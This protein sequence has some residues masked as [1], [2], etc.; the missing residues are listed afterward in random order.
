[1]M[2]TAKTP[3]LARRSRMF[4][5]AWRD[6]HSKNISIIK[7]LSH[8]LVRVTWCKQPKHQYS[9]GGLTFFGMLDMMHTTKTPIFASS[10]RMFW[11]AW[12][13]V[14]NQKTNISKEVSQF[15][16][17]L[18]M[19]CTARTPIF[20]RRSR[21]FWYAGHDAHRQDTNIRKEV[22]HFLVR[23]TWYTQPKHQY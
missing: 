8:F 11:Y 5:Y 3:I 23:L 19:M 12:R 2:H 22:S 21:I 18:D 17:M 9:H 7:E 15:F 16:C 4:W 10:S 1:M 14:H 20:A 6:V 13:N